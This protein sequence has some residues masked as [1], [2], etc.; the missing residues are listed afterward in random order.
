MR[1]GKLSS[2]YNKPN[3]D[4]TGVTFNCQVNLME[5]TIVAFQLWLRLIMQ[6]SQKHYQ[7]LCSAYE[8]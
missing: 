6:V 2:I 3:N 4:Q 8:I 7:T 5:L 1:K